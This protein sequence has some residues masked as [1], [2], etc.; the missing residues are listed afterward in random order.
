MSWVTSPPSPPNADTI[1]A[2][3][4]APGRA[5]IGVVRVSGAQVSAIAQALIG[6]LP[7]PRLATLANFIEADGSVIDQGIAL[8]FVAPHSFT[9]E[10]VLELQGHGGPAVMQGLLARCL[11]AG[12]RMAQ[13][14]EFTR[15]AYL[16]D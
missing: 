15:R 3:A 9:G 12:A 16:N 7:P 10:D 2:N 8:Y 13:P 5:G 6:K 14:G 11:E 1:A 4:T